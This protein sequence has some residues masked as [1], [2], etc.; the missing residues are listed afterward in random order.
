MDANAEALCDLLDGKLLGL[1][2]HRRG[3]F[4]SVSY[5]ANHGYGEP[6]SFG[7]TAIF[8]IER[9]RDQIIGKCRSKLADPCNGLVRVA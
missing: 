8:V 7:A 2:Q 4:V 5:P 3:D 9:C 1:F 6:F